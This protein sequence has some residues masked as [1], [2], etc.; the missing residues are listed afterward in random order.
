VNTFLTNMEQGKDKEREYKYFLV[1]V[2]KTNPLCSPDDLLNLL[3]IQSN[4]MELVEII[5]DKRLDIDHIRL[6]CGDILTMLFQ[7]CQTAMYLGPVKTSESLKKETLRSRDAVIKLMKFGKTI[8]Q[9]YS[10]TKIIGICRESI[11]ELNYQIQELTELLWNISE[12]ESIHDLMS[13]KIQAYSHNHIFTEKH[14]SI[15]S[16]PYMKDEFESKSVFPWKYYW[17]PNSKKLLNYMGDCTKTKL[18]VAFTLNEIVDHFYEQ[19]LHKIYDHEELEANVSLEVG[20]L[21]QLQQEDFCLRDKRSLQWP[22]LQHVYTLRFEELW[23]LKHLKIPKR[24]SLVLDLPNSFCETKNSKT[25]NI[26]KKPKINKQPTKIFNHHVNRT[27]ESN[28]PGH[29]NKTTRSNEET[30]N[31]SRSTSPVSV[32]SV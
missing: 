18:G 9:K 10:M 8:I 20:A 22:L 23:N 21:F 19:M 12:L 13:Y 15:L 31:M 27:S 1:F 29:N 25:T 32:K 28:C 3:Q 26:Q 17:H 24:S 14:H 7:F 6:K 2:K 11:E 4:I 30:D 16:K 5:M